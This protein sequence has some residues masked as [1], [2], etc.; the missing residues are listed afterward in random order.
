MDSAGDVGTLSHYFIECDIKNIAIDKTY[1]DEF[2]KNQID[3][4]ETSYLAFLEWKKG[5]GNFELICSEKELVSEQYQYGGTIDYILLKVFPGGEQSVVMIDFKTGS[6]IYEE[7]YYQLGAYENLW[8]ENANQP[9]NR[10]T[11][12]YILRLGKENG[13][14]EQRKIGDLSREFEI[15]KNCLNIYNLK[16]K[17]PF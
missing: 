9:E 2:A 14:F 7:A 17:L 1:V 6:G 3:L 16:K 15:F 12:K 13:D 4:A 11:E 8:N 5:F 10:I